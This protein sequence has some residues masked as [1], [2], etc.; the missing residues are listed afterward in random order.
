MWNSK[1]EKNIL[2]WKKAIKNLEKNV[3]NERVSN[4]KN[5]LL[6]ITK[7]IEKYGKLNFQQNKEKNNK[8][9]KQNSKKRRETYVNFR[10]IKNTTYRTHRALNG[11]S[12]SS[13]TN[14]I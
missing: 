3:H 4:K 5:G 14:D 7:K 13:S 6:I 1:N 12:K 9:R 10:L 11:L 8:S 2:Y